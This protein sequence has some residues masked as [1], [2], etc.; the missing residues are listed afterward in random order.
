MR[1]ELLKELTK[2]TIEFCF[3]FV[4]QDLFQAKICLAKVILC[5]KDQLTE[6]ATRAEW[7]YCQDWI[8]F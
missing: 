6:L 1:P 7:S 5:T 8:A 2:E 4:D 3:K